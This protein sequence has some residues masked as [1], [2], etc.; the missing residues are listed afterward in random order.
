MSKEPTSG[1]PRSPFVRAV[2][3]AVLVS[4][5]P[6]LVGTPAFA[7]G[8][9]Q[10]D[11][12]T[13]R[14]RARFQEGVEAFDKGQ[15][16]NA[17]L[18]FMEA[19]ALKKHP[20]VLLNLAQSCVRA[21]HP[22]EAARYFSQF[23]REATQATPAQRADAEKGLAEARAKG[24]RVEVTAPNG[25]EIL[26]AGPSGDVRLGT[27]PLTEPLDV[28]AGT[29]TLKGR[30][31]DGTVETV[32]V[33]VA[34]GQKTSVKLGPQASAAPTPVPVP[35]PVPPKTDPPKAE[36]PAEPPKAEPPAEPPPVEPPHDKK[37]GLFS[38]PKTMVPVF[39]GAGVGVLGLAGTII[40]AAAKGSAQ[41]SADQV[42]AEIRDAA[43]KRSVSTQ[44]ICTNPP[45]DFKKACSALTEN[46]D[47][48]DTNATLANVSVVVMV[49]GFVGAGAWYLFGPKRDAA[50]TASNVFRLRNDA[51]LVPMVTPQGGGLVLT[52]P[53]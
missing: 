20:A 28:D 17:R 15:W 10:D 33:T 50:P 47:A 44:G 31:P 32:T 29:T 8:A 45:A 4:L 9:A 30:A 49:V 21:G 53:F 23:L 22:G 34:A 16:E 11:A 25:T 12:L 18:S 40:F 7:Q 42:T 38:P 24:G 43:A 48:V 14:A 3:L 35:A 13:K 51:Q 6:T 26:V 37:P 2:S 46:N 27:T 41:S 39:V 19:Y 1:K 52:Q 36:S 5:A